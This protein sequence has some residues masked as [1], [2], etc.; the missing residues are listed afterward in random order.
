MRW[1]GLVSSFVRALPV[2]VLLGGE[3]RGLLKRLFSARDT[4]S[5]GIALV[6]KENCD[7]KVQMYDLGRSF[8]LSRLVA[9][10]MPIMHKLCRVTRSTSQSQIIPLDVY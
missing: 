7:L 2:L 3:G 9:H 4:A 8:C 10:A 6:S 5:C 1:P